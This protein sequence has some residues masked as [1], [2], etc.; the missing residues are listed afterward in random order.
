MRRILRSILCVSVLVAVSALDAQEPISP[1]QAIVRGPYL[2]IGTPT[3]V[4]VR[5]RTLVASS[6][7][8]LIGDR[9]FPLVQVFE[10]PGETTEHEVQ[11]SGLS[12]GTCYYYAIADEEGLL[13]AGSDFVFTTAPEVGS[14]GKTRIWVI[15]DSGTGDHRAAAVRDAYYQFSAGAPTDVWLMLGDN[16]YNSGTDVEHQRAVFDMYPELLRS[17]VA[18]PTFGNHEGYSSNP[19][20][21]EGFYFDIFSLPTQGEAGGVA[22][23]TESYYS[24]DYANIHFICLESDANS[25]VAETAM[26]DWLREDCADTTQEWIIG[27]WHHPPY[28]R[29]S[30]NSDIERQLIAMR[31]IAV[32]ILEDA[33]VDLVLAGHSHSYER[34]R[35]LHGHYGFSDSLLPGMFLGCGDGRVSGSGAYVKT[36]TGESAGDGAVY[37]VAGTSGGQFGGGRLDHPVMF[38]STLE[39]GSVVLDVEGA[40]LD[41]KFLTRSGDVLDEFTLLKEAERESVESCTKVDFVRG[42]ANDDGSID[43]SDAI[44]IASELFDGFGLGGCHAASDASDDGSVDISDAVTVVQR[45]FEGAPPLAPPYPDCG[46]D[47]TLDGLSCATYGH[48]I[49]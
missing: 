19:L 25:I 43:I 9:P 18:W 36:T 45:L 31:E 33:G 17:V 27:Y 11:V 24:F 42:D 41:M 2:Q 1:R 12:P 35:L 6:S 47:E 26:W 3:S 20:A 22:S 21:E 48:C 5:W 38:F 8:V 10:V 37:M 49:P 13:E 23:G 28:S 15:G 32:P 40:R 29:G 34:S 14:R 7:V 4:I 39:H 46:A 44:W 16:A 30:H